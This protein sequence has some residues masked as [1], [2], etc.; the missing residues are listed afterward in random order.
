MIM[1]ELDAGRDMPM[2][3]LETARI[4]REYLEQQGYRF[5]GERL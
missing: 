3:A 4:A 1:V 2:P 5:R